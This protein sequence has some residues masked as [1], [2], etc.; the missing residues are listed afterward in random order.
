[1]NS[2]LND[3]AGISSG[4]TCTPRFSVLIVNYNGGAY[5]PNALDSLAKQT[6]RDFEV[7]LV[8]NASTDGSLDGLDTRQLPAFTLLRESENHGYAGGMNLAAA[9]A[10]GEW[11]VGLNPDAVAAADWLEKI[12]NGISRHQRAKMFASAQLALE[13]P[14]TLDGA[15]DAYLII[16][17]PWRG[18]FGRPASELPA[19]GECFSPCGAGGVFERETFLKH[20]G[21]DERFF[22]FCEDVDLG[23]R[24]RLAGE[25]CILLPDAVIHHVGG[26]ISGR[27]SDFSIYHGFRNRIWT[28]AKNMPSVIFWLTLPAHIGLSWYLLIRGAMT[29]RFKQA[30]R[31]MRDGAAGAVSM[32]RSGQELRRNRRVGLW[33]LARTMAWNPFRMSTHRVHVREGVRETPV[34]GSS[35]SEAR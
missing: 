6:R 12:A 13:A 15:G 29:G 19:E 8:D 14:D 25:T 23:F 22:C 27:S 31:G 4:S 34:N 21:F 9:C 5:I 28:Y 32:R 20:G 2:Q 3:P 11:L 1:M 35:A 26:G 33:A 24:L 30:W 18:G 10:Q 17:M 7:I 16:G